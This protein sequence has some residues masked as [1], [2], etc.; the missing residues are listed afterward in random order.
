MT[1]TGIFL[2]NRFL[3]AW[4]LTTTFKRVSSASSCGVLFQMVLG[5]LSISGIPPTIL[6]GSSC[7]QVY[8]SRNC[9]R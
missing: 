7:T 6:E 1:I 4:K 8:A 2:V 5:P 3:L 9:D